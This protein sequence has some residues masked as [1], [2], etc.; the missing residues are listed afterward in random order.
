MKIKKSKIFI[1]NDN[2]FIKNTIKH[3]LKT[4]SGTKKNSGVVILLNTK[5][6]KFG[7]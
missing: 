6:L 5:S 3:V 7:K 1:K 4:F 2:K